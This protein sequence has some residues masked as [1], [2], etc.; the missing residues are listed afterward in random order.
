[1]GFWHIELLGGLRA[2][3]LSEGGDE[4]TGKTVRFRTHKT[5]ALLAMLA[6]YRRPLSRE[7]LIDELWP[8]AALETGRNNLRI[9]LS[10][11]R[12]QLEPSPLEAGSVIVSNRANIAL[13]SALVT[14]DVAAFESACRSAQNLARTLPDNLARSDAAALLPLQQA[15]QSACDAYSGALLPGFYENWI[16]PQEQRL[17]AQFARAVRALIEL[18]HER[19]DTTAWLNA[20]QRGLEI[21]PQNAD[22]IEASAQARHRPTLAPQLS[23]GAVSSAPISPAQ[24]SLAGEA[25]LLVLPPQWTP[26]V[27]RQNEMAQLE[28]L[29]RQ[30][31]TRFVT[32]WGAGGSGKTRLAIE[33][34]RALDENHRVGKTLS[35]AHNSDFTAIYFVPLTTVQT[36]ERLAAA[37]VTAA[38]NREALVNSE[39]GTA[40][41]CWDDLA[42]LL[43]GRR[44]LLILDNCEQLAPECGD[45]LET[46][47]ERWPQTTLLATSRRLLRTRGEQV[48]LLASLACPAANANTLTPGEAMD[49]EAVRLFV[50]RARAVRA[51]FA[52]TPRN[53]EIIAELVRRLEGSPLAIELAAARAGVLSPQ[54][55]LKQ[56]QTPLQFLTR[57]ASAPSISVAASNWGT[58]SER[59]RARHSG[60]RACVQWSFDLL[61]APLQQVWAQLAI[62]RGGWTLD[63]ARVVCLD[64]SD[65]ARA[66]DALDTLRDASMIEIISH[67]DETPVRFSM[68]ETLREFAHSRLSETQHAALEARHSAYFVALAERHETQYNAT[69]EWGLD[70]ASEP[71]LELPNWRAVFERA[72]F[73]SAAANGASSSEMH[74]N[75]LRVLGALWWFWSLHGHLREGRSLTTHWLPDPDASC[76]D[77]A[78]RETMHIW[79]RAQS[80]AGAVAFHVGAGAEAQR[81]IRVAQALWEKSGD[82]LS[83]AGAWNYL[84]SVALAQ[85]EFAAA[86]SHYTTSLRLYEQ[87][88]TP[89]EPDARHL[90]IALSCLASAEYAAADY[91]AAR[92]CIKRARPFWDESGNR[93]GQ[94][95]LLSIEG[96]IAEA[97]EE[98]LTARA[99][100]ARAL[101][102]RS[103]A[104]P[105]SIANA[106]ADVA[107]VAAALGHDDQARTGWQESLRNHWENGRTSDALPCLEG[108]ASV[109]DA[110]DQDACERAAQIYA[111]TQILRAETYV[112]TYQRAVLARAQ[113]RL[114]Q[115]LDDNQRR[116]CAAVGQT[117]SFGEIVELALQS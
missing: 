17:E 95:W 70:Q 102:L 93:G 111:A 71:E 79:A 90:A 88:P 52:L 84:G 112:P 40:S 18:C 76:A 46:L 22:W 19:R 45:F 65:E 29:L 66:L 94:G 14:T 36:V 115:T 39:T 89:A 50:E 48:L 64:N 47:L 56:L 98:W 54:A 1:M 15:W 106:R 101:E 87:Y 81:R 51:D 11:L 117:L 108:V 7:V 38:N 35:A 74:E 107:R 80:S 25:P 6:F 67:A 5:G 96:W 68:P 31:S 114:S 77:E 113:A 49:C 72:A 13:S 27:G 55:M 43:N 69:G 110:D 26:F 78:S 75:V 91:M 61:N 9:A 32:L 42:L 30:P 92:E 62:F 8:D 24:A 57:R 21:E 116:A 4:G 28:A 33:T 60:L 58:D 99:L 20:V 82:A 34:A 12:R 41:T 2:Y 83:A 37:I 105:R 86:R 100:H 3:S 23:L 73:E 10:S 104:A 85:G 16:L 97:S 63:A 59:E 44:A 109:F 53:V 103:T